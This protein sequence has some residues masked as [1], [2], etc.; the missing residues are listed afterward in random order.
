MRATQGARAGWDHRARADAYQSEDCAAHDNKLAFISGFTGS[1]GVVQFLADRAL[2][3]V[4]G[5]Y[6]VQARHQV[7]LQEFE[8][9]HLHNELFHL[10]LRYNL[11][12][13]KRFVFD[14]LLMVNSQYENLRTSGCDLV[15]VDDDPL[16]AILPDRPAAPCGETSAMPEAISGESSA[17]KRAR[18]ALV[19][20][21]WP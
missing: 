18:V 13:G 17:S 6:H 3:F 15:A 14:P 11:P 1:S 7:K 9:H 2:L 16:D 12:A 19:P 5:R 10:W 8:I 20:I 21:I 4:D